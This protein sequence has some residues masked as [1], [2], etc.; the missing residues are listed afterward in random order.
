MALRLVRPHG[1]GTRRDVGMAATDENMV[2]ARR[3]ILLLSRNRRQWSVAEISEE[4][5]ID[6]PA[7]HANLAW[8]MAADPTHAIRQYGDKFLWVL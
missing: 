5:G 4:L 6:Q 2:T 3:I 8:I 7:I 1:N